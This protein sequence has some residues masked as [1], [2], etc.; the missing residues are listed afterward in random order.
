MPRGRERSPDPA[1]H[2]QPG[3]PRPAA[4]DRSP[5]PTHDDVS[6]RMA[7]MSTEVPG[8]GSPTST[9]SCEA[10]TE[11]L[12]SAASGERTGGECQ[13]GLTKKPPS[14]SLPLPLPPPPPPPPLPPS[15]PLSPLPPPLPLPPLLPPLSSPPPSPSPSSLPLSPPPPPPLPPAGRLRL[16]DDGAGLDCQLVALHGTVPGGLPR[17]RAGGQE[18][19]HRRVVG[20]DPR[21][22]VADAAKPGRCDCRCSRRVPIP[23][24]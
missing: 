10:N 12:A 4:Q 8:I 19:S 5:T 18:A 3:S 15:P 11:A 21:H 2:A 14:L 1:M 13:A 24:C 6:H 17:V 23:W 9:W 7:V 20:P 16:R 22:Q